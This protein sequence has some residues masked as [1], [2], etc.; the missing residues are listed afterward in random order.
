MLYSIRFA[1]WFRYKVTIKGLENLTQE[2]LQ[3]PGGVLFLPNHPTV[4][5]DPTLVTL[6][7]WRKYPLRPIVVEY[8]YYTPVIN[9]FM[10]FLHAL[11]VPN[12][13]NTSNS[14]KKKKADQA[15]DAMALGLKNG[16]NF[17]IYPAGKV[18]R[19]GKELISGSAI[20]RLI[21]SVPEAN[22]V[23]VRTTGLWGSSFSRALT[24]Q[25]PFVF[26]TIFQ[27]IKKA[28]LNGL[29][30]TP[31]RQV[32]IEFV[33]AGKEFYAAAGSRAALNRYLENWYNQSETGEKLSLVS[34]SI[35]KEDLPTLPSNLEHQLEFDPATAPFEIRQKILKKLA[36]L[37]RLPIEQ[38]KYEMT[39]GSDL[40]LDSLDIAGIAAFLDEQFDL[41]GIPVEQLSTVSTLMG[42]ASKQIAIKEEHEETEG[43]TARWNR[44][45]SSL[46][47][48][49]SLALGETLPEVF[50]RTCDQRPHQSLCVDNASGI[51]TYA[52]AKMRVLLLAAYLKKMP[53]TSVGILLPSS[54]AAYLTILACQLAGKLP[55]MINWTVGPRHLEALAALSKIEVLISSWAFLD[56]LD[57]VDLSP[58]EEKI[59]T[60]EDLKN[61]LTLVDKLKAY[62]LS[63]QSA[64]T[65]LK[66]FQRHEDKSSREAVLLFTSGTENVPKG[67][68][69]SHENIL[70][71]QRSI[72]Q[73]VEI[74]EA[75]VLI[76]ILPPF[77][78]FGFTVSG[79]LPLMAGMRA[80]Y[81]PDPTNGIGVAKTIERWQGTLICGAPSFLKGV[82]AHARPAQLES[83]RL[84][85]TGA[86]KAPA[87]LFEM[88]KTLPS[89]RLME[90]Y[91][92]TE[93]APVLT[94]NTSGNPVQGVGKP[95]PE[96]ELKIV[97]IDTHASLPK[98]EVG[99]L[100]ARGPN[101]FSGY[102]NP[103]LSSPFISHAGKEWYNTG[104]LGQIDQEGNVLLAGRLKR[105]IKI[106]GEMIS[107]MAVEEIL[108]K[109]IR[110]RISKPT[111]DVPSAAVC[112]QE[113]AGEKA[114]IF[115]FTP[116]AIPVE[117]LNRALREAGFSNLV[118]IY[119]VHLVSEIPRLGSGKINYRTLQKQLDPL[120]SLEVA[121][122]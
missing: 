23:L 14:L 60:L 15:I 57:N 113:E 37:T 105:F 36:E 48:R 67:V 89:C 102:L 61:Q 12:F 29:F 32:T 8:M 5:V 70:S 86:E 90:G 110:R 42:I 79:L 51:L 73:T 109:E 53:G 30:F 41:P 108:E 121:T 91:G 26:T 117:E 80:A 66:K 98:G 49:A 16:E 62:F 72:L 19:Q 55:V 88:V 87:D 58:I 28:L 103:G 10:R 69:L 95:L 3:K 21:E 114:K 112:A 118:K 52:Q 44:P 2:T 68:P 54:V 7:V 25:S 24:N 76:S 85:V 1:L 13:L 63:K 34:Y 46:P 33:P 20:H 104:D 27:G 83:L 31:R 22:V 50:L 100:L 45:A 75:D 77:H 40:G 74:Q 38:I 6:A 119:A 99:L 82:F 78:S 107:L 64:A 18:K 4:F 59:L 94:L 84:C 17:L 43:T 116:Y 96:V 39:L 11:P 111:E 115:L 56:K 9:W 81:Y 97:H 35:W 122:V 93:C 71:N 106:G 120:P 47:A 92:V 65:L 101:L